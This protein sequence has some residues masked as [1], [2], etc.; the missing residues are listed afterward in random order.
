[1]PQLTKELV[2]YNHVLVNDWP[3]SMG[4]PAAPVYSEILPLSEASR[5]SLCLVAEAENLLVGILI[6]RGGRHLQKQHVSTLDVFF[7]HEDWRGQGIGTSLIRHATKW[8]RQSNHVARLE[9][10]IAIHNT[11]A[12]SLL[13]KE[14]FRLEGNLASSI[15][16]DGKLMNTMVLALLADS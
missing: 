9:V 15:R 2:R 5:N 12:L 3:P 1:M 11:V 13:K 6:C 8:L 16:I 14:G 4:M 10:V 7:V